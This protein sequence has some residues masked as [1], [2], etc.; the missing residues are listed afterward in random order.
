MKALFKDGQAVWCRWDG[1]SNLVLKAT[2]VGH[3]TRLDENLELVGFEYDV[4]FSKRNQVSADYFYEIM[5]KKQNYPIRNR[6]KES[7]L[8]PRRSIWNLLI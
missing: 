4:S 7:M 8:E 6:Y 3:S 1:S 5:D 2:I